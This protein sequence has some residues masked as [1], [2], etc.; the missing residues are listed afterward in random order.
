MING[1]RADIL[2]VDDITPCMDASALERRVLSNPLLAAPYGVT[3]M[4]NAQARKDLNTRSGVTGTILSLLR[5]AR[6][7]DLLDYNEGR[8][9]DVVEVKINEDKDSAKLGG[10]MNS[11][12]SLH[13]IDPL[14]GDLKV[15]KL[16]GLFYP[17][18]SRFGYGQVRHG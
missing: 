17:S 14:S 7:L 9:D 6:G 16:L 4:L 3:T 18:N 1:K 11:G 12:Y 8:H 13:S 2:I 5:R 15:S 10:L